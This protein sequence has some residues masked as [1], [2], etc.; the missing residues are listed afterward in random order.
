MTQVIDDKGRLQL[1]PNFK[2]GEVVEVQVSGDNAIF[3]SK[4]A[5]HAEA[6]EIRQVILPDGHSVIIG[7]PPIDSEG[8][9]KLLEDFP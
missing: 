2:P 5:D 3:I 8:V 1:P 4:A 7:L 9:K 6:S